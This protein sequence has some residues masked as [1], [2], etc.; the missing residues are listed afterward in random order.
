VWIHKV[1]L[2]CHAHQGCVRLPLKARI[3]GCLQHTHD[4]SVTNILDSSTANPFVSCCYCYRPAPA[5]RIRSCIVALGIFRLSRPSNECP[6]RGDTQARRN[7]EKFGPLHRDG[8]PA[9]RVLLDG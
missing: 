7:L 2:W 5:S 4:Q 8:Y 9:Q 3:V 1:G 6:G